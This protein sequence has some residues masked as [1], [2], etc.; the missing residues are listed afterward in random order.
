METVEIRNK[1]FDTLNLVED[2]T[3]LETVL[4][5]IEDYKKEENYLSDLTKNQLDEID[6]RREKYLSG[7]GNLY[8]WNQVKEDLIKNHGLQS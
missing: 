4:K 8:S 6:K 3:M 7:K 1:I 5:Y 2:S